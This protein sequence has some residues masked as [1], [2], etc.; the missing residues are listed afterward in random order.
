MHRYLHLHAS[1]ALT[2]MYLYGPTHMPCKN[3]HIH[4]CTYTCLNGYTLN[5]HTFMCAAHPCACMY[6]QGKARLMNTIH[7]QSCMYATA[8]ACMYISAHAQIHVPACM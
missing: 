1:F 5:A 6:I 7:E 8:H 4:E 3:M 2:R